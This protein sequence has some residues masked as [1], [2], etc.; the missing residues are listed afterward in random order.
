MRD[1]RYAPVLTL[2]FSL[3]LTFNPAPAQTIFTAAGLPHSHRASIDS[4]PVL[5]APLGRV[6]TMLFDNRTGRLLLHDEILVSRIEPDGSLLTMVGMGRGTEGSMADGTLASGLDVVVLRGMAQDSIGALYL[7]DA[8]AGRVYRVGL[9]GLVT[10]FA[11]GGVNPPGPQSDGRPATEAGMGSPRGLVFDS[12]GNLDIAEVY[13]HCIRRVDTAGIISTVFTLPVEAR[14]F[15]YFEGLAIDSQDNIYAAEYS[16]SA[17]WKIAPD[18]SGNIYIADT[19]NNR[20]RRIDPDGVITTFAGNGT[21]GFSGDSGP[22][23]KAQLSGPAQILIDSAGDV[24]IADFFNQRIRVVTPDGTISTLAGNGLRDSGLVFPAIGDNGPALQAV[25]NDA[26]SAAFAPSGDLYV[27]DSNA[28]RVRKIAAN[29]TITTV[30]GNGQNTYLGDGVPA[31]Q[32]SIIRPVTVATDNAGSV[33]FTTG[34]SRVMKVTPDGFLHLVAGM[35]TGIGLNRAGGDGGPAVAATL[36]EPKGLAIDAQGNVFIGDTSNAR[37]RKVASNG[38][39]STVAGPGIQGTDYWNGVA[40]DPKGALYVAITHAGPPTFSSEVDRVNSDGSLT[41]VAGNGQSCVNLSQTFAGDGSNILNVPLCTVVG[42]SFDTQGAMYIPEAYY[43][44][45]LR[46]AP[47]GTV[48][49]TAGGAS[50]KAGLGDGGSPLQASLQAGLDFSPASVALDGKG[51]MFIPQAGTN[52]IR[53]VMPGPLVLRFSKESVAFQGTAAA[54]QAVQVTT[55]IAEPLP[56]LVQLHT[57]VG[58]AWLSANRVTGQT[59]DMLIISANAARLP[60]GVYAG[61]VQVSIPGGTAQSATLPV[62]LTV[63]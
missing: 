10:T 12:R 19:L 59:D 55:N 48:Q 44:A 40:I 60:S 52:R 32:A 58:G 9:D 7:S 36:N 39:I 16:G 46:V 27:A 49:R 62:T 54:D 11:G 30:A 14:G 34:D 37:L 25:F 26:N 63:P 61:T 47:D 22:A 1:L 42:L 17:I 6:Y 3:C 53:E 15:P 29:G 23:I 21:A 33:Y 56:F 38:I 57:T 18:G 35:G 2:G 13:C 20:V 8:S 5:A 43:T 45:V 24:L 41:R 28:S 31:V 4:M 50:F 51:N